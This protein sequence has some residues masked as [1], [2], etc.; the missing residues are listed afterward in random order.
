[1]FKRAKASYTTGINLGEDALI[2]YKLLL[3]NPK[4]FQIKK[5][6]YHYRR[7]YGESSYTNQLSMHHIQQLQYIYNWLKQNYSCDKYQGI[8]RQRALDIA[9]AAL[10]AKDS[11]NDYINNFLSSEISWQTLMKGRLSLE[12]IMVGIEKMFPLSFARFILKNLYRLFYK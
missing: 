1:M 7:L 5:H 4:I 8:R 3:A 9:F 10:R 12:S 11:D 6:L 2:I